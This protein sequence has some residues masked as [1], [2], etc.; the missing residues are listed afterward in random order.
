MFNRLASDLQTATKDNILN[1]RQA[2]N[3]FFA[4]AEKR[5][6]RMA[7]IATGDR[8]EALDIVQDA[9]MM[10]VRKYSDRTEEEWGA[11]FYRIVQNR[12]KDWYRRQKVRNIWHSWFG[13]DDEDDEQGIDSLPEIVSNNPEKKI[14]QYRMTEQLEKALSELPLR[15]Q[16]TFLLRTWE[17]LDV[18]QTASAMGISEG[19]VKTHYSR[20]VHSLRETLGEY[21]YE[22]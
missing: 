7:Q 6:Y 22:E 4:R 12:I 3:Q 2:L 16:Q 10:L 21:Q 8:E 5:A 15:Q 19:S 18:K 11:L 9:M 17:G 14:F 20:A 13:K 1:Q